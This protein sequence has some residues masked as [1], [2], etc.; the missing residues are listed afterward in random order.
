MNGK[1]IKVVER[2][3]LDK[4]AEEIVCFDL[5]GQ[6]NICDY[7]MVCSASNERQSQA[8]CDAIDELCKSEL[9]IRPL[10]I[11]GRASGHWIALDYNS[12]IIHVFVK[13]LRNFYALDS[14]WP[15]TECDINL[16]KE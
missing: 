7:Q 13:K 5:T 9:K 10:S 12:I 8:I 1:I 2:A 15:N 4:K 11:E 3:M 16:I 14:L 6:S